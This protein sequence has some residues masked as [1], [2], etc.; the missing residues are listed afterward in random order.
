MFKLLGGSTRSLV[1]SFLVAW[2]V[3]AALTTLLLTSLTSCNGNSEVLPPEIPTPP[4]I[5][6][7]TGS[8]APPIAPV[9]I[10]MAKVLDILVGKPELVLR[11]DGEA[12]RA[13]PGFTGLLSLIESEEDALSAPRSK[14]GFSP[15]EVVEE[16]SLSASNIDAN[17]P[18]IAARLS[19]APKR[20]IACLQKLVDKTEP[21][22]V[23]QRKATRFGRSYLPT[24]RQTV[25]LELDGLFVMGTVVDVTDALTR[26]DAPTPPSPPKLLGRI[27]SAPDALIVLAAELER[28]PVAQAFGVLHGQGAQL[29]FRGVVT[30][31]QDRGSSAQQN[32]N[33]LHDLLQ[34]GSGE[35]ARELSK[36]FRG[37]K[38]AKRLLKQLNRIKVSQN[39]ATVRAQATLLLFDGIDQ[40]FGQASGRRRLRSQTDEARNNLRAIA[41]AATS[42]FSAA[43]TLCGSARPV[44]RRVPQGKSYQP[45]S[46]VPGQDFQSGD[47]RRGWKCLKFELTQPHRYRYSYNLAGSFKGPSRGGPNPGQGGFEVS[48]EGD[49][50]ADG[51]TSL[52]TL[53][54][55]VDPATG[56]LNVASTVFVVDELE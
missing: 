55:S 39:G 5:T 34:R 11:L 38:D 46:N 48:A 44:P 45:R 21:T 8:T 32:A 26:Y 18:L 54:G 35:L 43:G 49:L 4:V 52:F 17:M 6:A 1:G 42:A 7:A 3:L 25:A 28:I 51:K 23:G 31:K 37:L 16:L 15:F 40:L 12:L 47:T 33:R 56:Q 14:C 27:E 10:K 30:M 22:T 13:L 20:A 53:T 2:A 29:S 50:D 19:V 36:V 9:A 41:N 24:H